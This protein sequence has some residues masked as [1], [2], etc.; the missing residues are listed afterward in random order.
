ML[1]GLT[2]D[3]TIPKVQSLLCKN[4]HAHFSYQLWKLCGFVSLILWTRQIWNGL[5]F[6]K[7][8]VKK[9]SCIARA[10]REGELSS[11]HFTHNSQQLRVQAVPSAAR[12]RRCNY[13]FVKLGLRT[14]QKQNQ[15]LNQSFY[16][17]V[18]QHA[19][20][21]EAQ[22]SY[23]RQASCCNGDTLECLTWSPAAAPEERRCPAGPGSYLP[24]L[25]GCLRHP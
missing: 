13:R 8:P 21:Q 19:Q 16:K 15:E 14:K 25:G 18:I 1:P 3:F 10:L 17:S 11:V 4:I 5:S 7:V 6:I 20:K 22:I 9:S 24:A 23:L 2:E 12:G